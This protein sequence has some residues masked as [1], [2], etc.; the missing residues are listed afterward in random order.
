[1]L[2]KRAPWISVGWKLLVVGDC[3]LVWAYSY[4]YY[5]WC[6]AA[7]HSWADCISGWWAKTGPTRLLWWL[8]FIALDFV[9]SSLLKEWCILSADT[10]RHNLTECGGAVF[11]LYQWLIWRRILK[12]LLGMRARLL[13][14]GGVLSKGNNC[15]WIRLSCITFLKQTQSNG[16]S[17]PCL[18]CLPL[19]E[20][21]CSRGN[22]FL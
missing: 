8:H 7:F 21:P 20:L 1:M 6:L 14:A 10:R 5:R 19:Q 13:G 2:F 16:W 9:F 18:L 3:L 4:P 12:Y 22:I 11:L 15:S 17:R